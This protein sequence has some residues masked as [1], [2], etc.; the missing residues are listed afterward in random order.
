MRVIVLSTLILLGLPRAADR[1]FCIESLEALLGYNMYSRLE[2]GQSLRHSFK[3]AESLELFP[4]LPIKERVLPQISRMKPTVGVEYL[5]IYR[6][7]GFVG[8][9][10]KDRPARE[11]LKIYNILRS[12]STLRGIEYYS[13]SRKRMRTFF[14]DAY[15]IDSPK[16]RRRLDDPLVEEIPTN[17]SFF[18]FLRDSSLGDYVAEVKYHYHFDYFAMHIQNWSTLW[19]FIF[20]IVQPRDL[21]ML[22][23]IVPDGDALLFYG[24][25]YVNVTNIFGLAEGRTASFYNRL[26]ALFHWFKTSY[27][28]RA[29]ESAF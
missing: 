29:D 3:A 20:P 25:A 7:G 18:T 10:R 19:Q 21:N 1:V 23:I 12:V 4:S 11:H 13:A 17:A 28:L 8:G 2:S 22:V 9:S 27:E 24:L 16:R 5:L 15:V 6:P 26:K 14:Y